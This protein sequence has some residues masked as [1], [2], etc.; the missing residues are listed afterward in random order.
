LKLASNRGPSVGTNP[1]TALNVSP[2]I[3]KKTNE[4]GTDNSP[5]NTGINACPLE[6][7]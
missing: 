5:S 2:I 3:K 7:L 1:V 6:I 4:I